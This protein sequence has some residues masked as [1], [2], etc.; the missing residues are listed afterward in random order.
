MQHSVLMAGQPFGL[1]LQEKLLPQYLK[2][3]SYATHGVGKVLVFHPLYLSV[4]LLNTHIIP[5][6]LLSLIFFLFCYFLL[7]L[8][9][10]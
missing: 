6:P 3:L 9:Y 1:G 8:S 4:C 10:C 5:L 7:S 2:E